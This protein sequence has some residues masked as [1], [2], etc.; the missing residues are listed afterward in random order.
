MKI[1]VN[2]GVGIMKKRINFRA[3]FLAAGMLLAL[4]SGCG[5]NAAEQAG[6]TVETV[7]L[8][9][10]GALASFEEGVITI[11]VDGKKQS[12]AVTGKTAFSLARGFVSGDTF[13]VSYDA[14]DEETALSVA[15]VENSGLETYALRGT[16]KSLDEYELR[17][18]LAD[19][20]TANFV[21]CAAALDLWQGLRE[22]VYVELTC[23]GTG[24]DGSCVWVQRITDNDGS[25]L[26]TTPAPTTSGELSAEPAE[27]ETTTEESVEYAWPYEPCEDTVWASV[28]ANLR[29]GPGMEYPC[30]GDVDCGE[31][32]SRCGLSGEWSAVM[33]DGK[34]YYIASELL[35]TERPGKL[36]EITYDANGGTAAPEAQHKLGG[37]SIQLS[38]LEPVREGWR[39]VSW[40]T[41]EKGFGITFFAGDEYEMDGDA[42][43]YAQWAE[44]EDETAEETATTSSDEQTTEETTS[45]TVET[46]E[47]EETAPVRDTAS[48]IA[49]ILVSLEEDRLTLESAGLEYTFDISS[50]TITAERGVH[51]GDSVT[52]YYAGALGAG[53]DSAAA[54][55][56]RVRISA[57]AGRV[58]GEVTAIGQGIVA[59]SL[60]KTEL[61]A[62]VDGAAAEPGDEITLTL[63]P[64][65]A[66]S[67]L[68]SAAMK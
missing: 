36:S 13:T 11:E 43:L 28:S 22:G 31:E 41:N 52:L 15:S 40:N 50:A 64:A 5:D 30:V 29:V 42:T 53:R 12:F 44:A 19:G 57:G 2:D 23:L 38:M 61:F 4:L 7:L 65:A 10:E 58:T 32:L 63:S 51:P 18:T 33:L 27:E 3:L 35:L 17:V 25:A 8:E 34:E 54:P 56:V 20:G 9:A 45:E 16:V 6:E 1:M 21:L 60:G 37:E 14:A 55:A 48:A 59:V 67:N 49:G 68:L 62:A 46:A 26:L 39:F 66:R 47:T 24:E